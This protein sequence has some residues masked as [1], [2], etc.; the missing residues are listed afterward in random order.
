[1]LNHYQSQEILSAASEN[2][3]KIQSA[4]IVSQKPPSFVQ[5]VSFDKLFYEPK[6]SPISD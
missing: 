6:K 5:L 3:T 4:K 1:M 2:K